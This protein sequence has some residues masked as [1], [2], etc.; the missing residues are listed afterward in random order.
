MTSVIE[1]K[2]RR[3]STEQI[4]L[5]P[6]NN[7]VYSTVYAPDNGFTN[8]VGAFKIYDPI[9]ASH[10]REILSKTSM[11]GNLNQNTVDALSLAYHDPE[12]REAAIEFD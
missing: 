1:S 10:N 4:W 2:L 11:E 6:V 12:L 8:D 3:S 9:V 7:Q 5:N